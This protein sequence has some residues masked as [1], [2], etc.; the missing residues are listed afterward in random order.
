MP[1]TKTNGS[2][3]SSANLGFKAKLWLAAD[4][5]SIQRVNV[6]RRSVDLLCQFFEYFLTQFTSAE[7]KNGGQFY[8]PSLV[9]RSGGSCGIALTKMSSSRSKFRGM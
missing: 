9:V 8:T 4:I 5:G 1:R 6:A 3:D 2:K 7:G